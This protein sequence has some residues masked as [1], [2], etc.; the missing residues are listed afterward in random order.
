MKALVKTGLVFGIL[1][2]GVAFVAI[3]NSAS[4][5]KTAQN[6][7]EQHYVAPSKAAAQVVAKEATDSGKSWFG[8]AKTNVAGW[9]GSTEKPA[10]PVAVDSSAVARPAHVAAVPKTSPVAPVVVPAAVTAP[11][12]AAAPVAAPAPAPAVAVVPASVA[13]P[14]VI[15]T[16]SSPAR[17][18]AAVPAKQ[19]AASAPPVP[20]E[21][22]TPDLDKLVN[23]LNTV[24]KK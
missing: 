7:A 23:S 8:S 20:P 17:K 6:Y 12:V 9:F 13:T 4:K 19:K 10:G 5:R 14:T 22:S 21:E 1:I 24:L 15:A 18:V 16:H 2:F 11:A 3:G